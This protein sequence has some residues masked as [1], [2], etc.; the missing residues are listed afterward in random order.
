MNKQQLASKIWTMANQ[1]RSKIDASEYKDY[2]LGFMFYKFLSEQETKFFLTEGGSIE[3]LKEVGENSSEAQFI[4]NHVGYFIE[5]KNLFSTWI[6]K[7]LDFNIGDVRDAISAFNR[8]I[9]TNHKKVFKEIFKTLDSGLSALGDNAVAQTSAVMKLIQL[10]D[11]IP[12][13]D[14][15]DYDVL[16]FIYEYLI[17]NFAANAGKKAGEFYTPHEVSVLMSEIVADHLKDKKEIKIYDPTSG[18]GSLLLN[19]GQSVARHINGKDNIK[20]YA[21]EISQSTFNL[22]RMNLIMRGIKPDN[23]VARRGDTLGADWPYF[24]DDKE[25]SY[26]PLTNIDAVVSNPPYSIPWNSDDMQFD[27]RFKEYG[28]APKG[29]ADYAFL[30]HSLFHLDARGIMTIVLPHGVLFR[31][32]EEAKIRR[33][34][35]ESNNIDAVIGLPANIF[36]GTG[37]PTLIMVLKKD[38]TEN[39]VLIIDASRE[40]IKE[41]K[42]NKL[43]ARDIRKI[44]DTYISRDEIPKYS[45]RV[46]REEIRQNDYNLNIPRYVDSSEKPETIDIYASLFGGIPK[47]ELADLDLEFATFPSLYN[48]LF[49]D[50]GSPYVALN[51]EDV[52]GTIENNVDVKAYMD[53]YADALDGMEE[54]LAKDLIESMDTVSVAK[55][56]GVLT[57]DLFH[58]LGGIPLVDKYDAYQILDDNWRGISEDLEMIQT[59]GREAI[60]A[61]DPNMVAKK[62]AEVQSGWKG[63]I[64]PFDIVQKEILSDNLN[65]ISELEAKVA[66]IQSQYDEIIENIPEDDRGDFL[67]DD[68]TAFVPAVV[69]KLA[70]PYTKG[71]NKKVPEPGS[72]DETLVCVNDLINREKSLNKK[73]REEKNALL[74][75]TIKAIKNLTPSEAE[76]LL[77][78]KWITPILDGLAVLPQ[79]IVSALESRITSLTKKYSVTLSNLEGEICRTESELADMIDDLDGPEYDLLGLK[80]LQKI[81]RR[82]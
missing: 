58:R 10:I 39:D 40:F 46:S 70:A 62:D 67:N 63:H 44:A 59:E 32:N 30:L 47:S 23:I 49:I 50:D 22:T 6:K 60:T 25:N 11:L 1:M 15:Q 72:L 52:K 20:Y 66:D 34:L 31:G 33:N 3:E 2:I 27:P 16:G 26:E 65:A 79:S 21:Q 48:E 81:L 37:I 38:R 56:E 75:K 9:N 12:M 73:I 13:D 45:R 61:V 14:R 69:A 43:R 42:S 51:S 7:G 41:G 57:A 17:S 82:Q 5:Y 8:L 19:I 35:I 64:L 29:K 80:E 18:S 71:K 76:N 28:V 68:N 55:E 53:A 24:D 36:F 74:D 77:K 4:Q 78:I 54:F